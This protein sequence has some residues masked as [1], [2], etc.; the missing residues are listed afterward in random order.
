MQVSSTFNEF[1]ISLQVDQDYWPRPPPSGIHG[2]S[3]PPATRP[4]PASPARCGL[5][6]G[7]LS[8]AW[9]AGY[10]RAPGLRRS[11]HPRPWASAPAI[12]TA[13]RIPTGTA[14]G[15]NHAFPHKSAPCVAGRGLAF[16]EGRRAMRSKPSIQAIGLIGQ[17]GIRKI[18]GRSE[19]RHC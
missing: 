1:A 12:R 9:L 8:G 19:G 5:C 7:A 18:P 10:S 2:A 4:P 3:A 16:V 13:I 14:T 17:I 6:P 11:I 15:T